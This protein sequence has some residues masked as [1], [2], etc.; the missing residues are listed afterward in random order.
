MKLPNQNH[1][2]QIILSRVAENPDKEVCGFLLTDGTDIKEV[3][4]GVGD[5]KRVFEDG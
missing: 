1:V 5:D 4:F 2:E 3:Y